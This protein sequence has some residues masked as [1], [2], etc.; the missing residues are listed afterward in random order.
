[1]NFIA[2]GVNLMV[3]YELFLSSFTRATSQRM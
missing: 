3:S 2:S 1:M